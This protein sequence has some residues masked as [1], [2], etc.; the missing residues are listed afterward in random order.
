MRQRLPLLLGRFLLSSAILAIALL[1]SSADLLAQTPE[2]V[3]AEGY[4]PERD[5]QQRVVPCNLNDAGSIIPGA[6]TAQSNDLTLD[7]LFLCFN[8][9]ILIDHNG[10]QRLDGDPDLSTQAGVGYAWYSCV[11][12]VDGPTLGA[13]SADPCL[14]PNAGAP[15]GSP[16]FFI[17]TGGRFDGDVLFFN[18]GD[19]QTAFNGGNPYLVWFAPIT[20]DSLETVGTTNFPRYENGGSCV[21]VSTDAAFAVVYLNQ[22]TAGNLQ[23]NN[24]SGTFDVDGGLPGWRVGDF[25]DISITNATD[26]SITGTV[27]NPDVAGGGRVEFTVPQ[28][29]TYTIRVTDSK[30]CDVT[31]LSADMS[32]CIPPDFVKVTIDT[33]LGA[34]GSTVCVPVTVEGF[35]NIV[36]FQFGLDYDEVLLRFDGFQNVGIAPFGPTDFNDNGDAVIVAAATFSMPYNIADGGT[37]FEMCFEVLGLEGEFGSVVETEPISGIEFGTATGATLD[38]E[39]C[40]GGVVITTNTLA[41]LAEQ[42][43]QGCGGE[44]EN[45]FVARVFGGTPPYTITWELQGSGNVQGPQ[46]LVAENQ[47]FATAANLAPGVY[48]I[49]AVDAGGNT[50]VVQ[51]SIADGPELGLY[52]DRLSSLRCFGDANGALFA[53]PTLNFTD[54]SN[55]GSDYTF[56]WDTGET[57]QGIND[58]GVGNYSVTVTDSRGCTATADN[59]ITA[60]S[61]LSVTLAVTDATCTGLNDGEI[62][63]NTTGG[64]PMGANYTYTYTTPGGT[65]ANAP[66][67]NITINAESG[68]YII[69]VVDDNGCRVDTTALVGAQRAIGLTPAITEIQCAGDMN[70]EI[71]VVASATLGTAAPPFQF[72]WFGAPGAVSTPT[73]STLGSLGQGTYRVVAEDADGCLVRDTFTLIEPQQLQISLD[74]STPESCDPGG[75]GTA[76]ISAMGGRNG[77][78][79]YTFEWRD[80]DYNI[81]ASA[82]MATGLTGGFYTGYVIDESG[83]IDSLPQ[84]IEITAPDRPVVQS[85]DDDQLDCNGDAN[86]SLTV[87]VTPGAAPIDRIEWDNGGTGTMIDNLVAGIYEVIITDTDGCVTR[88]TAEVTEPDPLAVDDA[89]LVPPPCFEGGEGSITLTLIGGTGP[90]TFDWSDGTMGV[91]ANSISGPTITEGTYLVTVT[92]ANDCPALQESYFLDDPE[93]INPTESGVVAASCAAGVEDGQLTVSAE[94]P[95]DPAATFLF[96]WSS[97]ETG[98]GISSTATM[99]QGGRITVAIQ[100]ASMVC[101]PQEFSYEIPAPDPLVPNFAVREDVRCFGE[102]SGRIFIDEVQGGTPGFT[103]AWTYNGQTF[104]GNELNDIPAATVSLEIQDANG[105]TLNEDIVISEPDELVLDLDVP[106]TLEP[107]CAGYDDGIV[108]LATSGGNLGAPYTYRWNDDPNRNAAVARDLEAGTY[109]VIVSDFKGCTDELTYTL[110]EPDAIEYTLSEFEDIVCFGDLTTLTVEDAFGGQGLTVDDYQVS[111]NGSS[112]QPIGTEFQVPGGIVIPIQVIDAAECVVDDEIIIPAPPAITVNLPDEVEVELGDSV[113][114]RPDIFPGGAPI[115]FDNIVWTPDTL[116]SFRGSNFADPYVS[117]LSSTVYTVTVFDEDGCSQSASVLVNV[118]RNRNVFIPNAFSPNND[119]NNDVFKILTGPG[120]RSINYL[121]IFNR[122]GEA[123]Y[124]EEDLQL[125]DFGQEAAW[126][127]TYRGRRVPEGV[128]VYLTEVT[129][130]DGKSFIYK[131]DVMVVH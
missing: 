85:L 111:I 21:S 16:P 103:Y 88:Q 80:S 53:V 98:S 127:G 46:I 73:Q 89:A 14:I 10:D 18:R 101:P 83:C 7:T 92:D 117:P 74:G 71:T 13:V 109:T 31:T 66:S 99:L 41:L 124:A 42:E 72:T 123:I 119:S 19:V 34:P 29:G 58:L 8:D 2:A 75:D 95:G 128:Y 131:G 39:F 96:N 40:T 93:G 77:T 60:P 38:Y 76:T 61:A 106:G 56:V 17:S 125:N 49:T 25:Y 22:L 65:T 37:L 90:Y 91:G 79:P 62:R 59:T 120:V 87:A 52:I 45:F 82:A 12:S 24:C 64:T 30:G 3:R 32:A 116:I 100:E 26:P 121:R 118:D 115:D 27:L 126:D 55:P 84:P 36:S 20:F 57:S 97:G 67:N 35:Q 104:T 4:T 70:G 28:A 48:D 122:W 113:R 86:G 110:T 63:V 108:S 94:L 69:S 50:D 15:A 81:V 114:L 11:P 68:P 51:L 54:V 78:Q 130:L 5:A 105:C 47:P 102:S 6:A 1:V 9:E 112:Y 44:D 107:S 23:L 129:F 33:I 43:G